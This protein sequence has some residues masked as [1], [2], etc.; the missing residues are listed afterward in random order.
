MR[1]I[2]IFFLLCLVLFSQTIFPQNKKNIQ[3]TKEKN[4][5]E[6]I[7]QEQKRKE[8]EERLKQEEKKKQEIE[9]LKDKID[10]LKYS[11]NILEKREAFDYLFDHLEKALPFFYEDILDPENSDWYL[12]NILVMLS[13]SESPIKTEIL[14]QSIPIQKNKK[15]YLKNLFL[16]LYQREDTKKRCQTILLDL[17]ENN[18]YF[19]IVIQ[20][21]QALRDNFFKDKIIA[22]LKEE[23]NEWY[24]ENLLLA[25]QRMEIKEEKEREFLATFFSHPSKAIQKT[26]ARLFS[27]YPNSLEF[28]CHLFEE[29]EDILEKIS[30]LNAI[31]LMQ[32]EASF[33]FLIQQIQEHRYADTALQFF[34]TKNKKFS[35]NIVNTAINYYEQKTSLFTRQ[36]YLKLLF[37]LYNNT[38]SILQEK[39]RDFL[40][41]E[42]LKAESEEMLFLL[43]ETAWQ[44]EKK[45]EYF[46]K[47]I[48][49]IKGTKKDLFSWR[50]QK[51]IR[52]LLDF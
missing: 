21:I 33:L 30:I 1:K 29:K 26:T 48:E 17:I 7:Q 46:K 44:L 5:Q 34:T 31:G 8:E 15:E 18:S 43:L 13:F 12:K 3:T 6:Q 52:L 37:L 35:E 42:M 50:V 25:L 10:K 49:E 38:S 16:F 9:Y 47:T 36:N 22:K 28:L 39:I 11:E 41:T 19:M 20:T 2:K 4:T 23:K 51:F 45:G 24:I 27:Y 40:K 32:T 14:F